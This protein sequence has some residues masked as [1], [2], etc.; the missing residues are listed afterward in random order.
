VV[1]DQATLERFGAL[2]DKAVWSTPLDEQAER[3]IRRM[4]ARMERERIPLSDDPQFHLKLGRGSLSDVEWTA[5]LLQLRTGTRAASTREA[6]GL[7]EAGGTLAPSDAAKLEAAYDFC[8]A[9]RNR[10]HLVGNYVAGTGAM[11]GGGADAMPHQGD[12]LSHLA[13]SLETTPV[14]LR[15]SYR[16]VTRRSRKVV[17]RLF[18]DL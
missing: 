12:A 9:T 13:R 5:Q 17:E 6:L 15:E 18:Y 3:E 11:A 7:L 8:G 4:K 14:D 16:R 10:W 2:A 1:G